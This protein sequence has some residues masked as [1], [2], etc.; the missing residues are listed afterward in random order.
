M[1]SSRPTHSRRQPIDLPEGVLSAWRTSNR[2]TLQLVHELPPPV[3]NLAVPGVRRRTIRTIAAHLHNCRR[4]WIRTLG[5]EHGIAVPPRVDRLSLD[6]A[7]VL[8]YF[9]AHEAHHRGQIVMAARQAGHRL[10]RSITDG[11]WQWKG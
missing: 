1:S 7:H 6:V 4:S 9:V 2:A 8:T 11:L 5:Q 3:W 10:P